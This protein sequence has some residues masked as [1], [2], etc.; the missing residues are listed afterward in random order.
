MVSNTPKYYSN[1]YHS[2]MA[3]K[4]LFCYQCEE[5]GKIPIYFRHESRVFRVAFYVCS[6]CMHFSGFIE[7]WK[8][9]TDRIM[10][11]FNDMRGLIMMRLEKETNKK[12]VLLIKK[13]NTFCIKCKKYD[14]SKL[15]VRNRIEKK[16]R[17]IGYICKN[18]RTAFFVN[19]SDLKFSKGRPLN[20]NEE[21]M[22]SFGVSSAEDE[23]KPIEYETIRIKKTDL[24]KLENL[25]IEIEYNV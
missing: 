22:G 9:K 20:K 4:S 12:R 18:C 3:K 21:S 13:N 7:T 17:F 2:I 11:Y 19:T 15:Y 14:Y 6:N 1:G 10:P 24:A 23:E 5:D 16:F 8:K 25:R